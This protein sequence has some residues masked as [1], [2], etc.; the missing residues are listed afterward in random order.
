MRKFCTAQS[1]YGL[2][3]YVDSDLKNI[4]PKN[5]NTSLSVLG[6]DDNSIISLL[7]MCHALLSS[8]VV[9]LATCQDLS[10]GGVPLKL[11]VL[12]VHNRERKQQK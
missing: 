10:A 9:S 3:T 1:A 6:A 4:P 11:V 5:G 12:C 8:G 2:I 7:N